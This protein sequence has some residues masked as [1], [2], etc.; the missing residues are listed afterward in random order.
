LE[1]ELLFKRSGLGKLMAKCI[2]KE[3]FTRVRT[4]LRSRFASDTRGQELVEFAFILPILMMLLMGIFYMGRAISVY[5]A[6]GRAAR[7]GARA[8]LATTCAT[9]GDALNTAAGQTAINNALVS[10]SLNPSLVVP[11]PVFTAA[12]LNSSDPTN[13]Q[14][15]GVT[16]TVTYPVQ[17]NIPFTGWNG[18][19]INLSQTVT[20]RQEF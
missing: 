7:E 4:A 16:V 14:V 18:T 9:C 13:Y 8:A 20:M 3:T 5:Q 11:P 10:A 17:L 2:Q 1:I 12:V 6:L 19:T 15:N